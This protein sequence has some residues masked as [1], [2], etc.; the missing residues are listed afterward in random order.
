MAW[1]NIKLRRKTLIWREI[2]RIIPNKIQ[3]TKRNSQF[4]FQSPVLKLIRLL[5]KKLEPAH[6][7]NEPIRG[8]N[9]EVNYHRLASWST[10]I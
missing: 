8:Q 2:E 9:Q 3:N 1:N 4:A 6:V 5:Q 7:S 10:S